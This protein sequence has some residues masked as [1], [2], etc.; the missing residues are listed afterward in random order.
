MMRATLAVAVA[1]LLAGCVSSSGEPRRYYLLALESPPAPAPASA[2]HG[3]LAVASTVAVSFYDSTDIA[4]SP[5]PGTRA[6]YRAASWTEPPADA[7]SR[8]LLAMLAANGSFESV[9]AATSG[10]RTDLLLTTTLLDLHHEASKAPGT[11]RVELAAELID[12]RSHAL[13]ARKTIVAEAPAPTF[14]A[15]GAVTGLRA[16]TTTALQ[17]VG[18]WVAAVRPAR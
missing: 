3:S 5:T 13:V 15:A 18:A 1:V 10:V 7:M 9:A 2:A 16:A 14:D 8:Q 6:Y 11:A 4:Y 12:V 17:E